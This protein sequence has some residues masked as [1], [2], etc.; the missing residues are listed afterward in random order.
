VGF[1]LPE[2]TG[3]RRKHGGSETSRPRGP[4]VLSAYDSMYHRRQYHEVK[5]AGTVIRWCHQL[6]HDTA[7]TVIRTRIN[8]PLQPGLALARHDS[9]TDVTHW[10][11]FMARVSVLGFRAETPGEEKPGW[12]VFMAAGFGFA[13]PT[14]WRARESSSRMTYAVSIAST[15]D[16]ESLSGHG[17]PCHRILDAPGVTRLLIS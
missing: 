2:R 4:Q 14:T 7:N 15:D 3:H 6:G 11:I 13:G 1:A 12:W 9:L 5:Q 17:S 16:S 8:K 10:P